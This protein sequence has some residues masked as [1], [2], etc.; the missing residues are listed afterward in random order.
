MS[1]TLVMHLSTFFKITERTT[2]RP[3]RSVSQFGSPGRVV[4]AEYVP[5]HPVAV[6]EVRQLLTVVISE[7]S[8]VQVD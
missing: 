6:G 4:E 1:S 5:E 3:G 8:V 2:I 7:V